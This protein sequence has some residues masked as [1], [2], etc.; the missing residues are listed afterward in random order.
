MR[1]ELEAAIRDKD[2]RSLVR[3]LFPS[4]EPL[5]PTQ[6][7]IVR[8]VG[9]GISRRLVMSCHTRFGKTYCIALG[10]ALRILLDERPLDFR[11][12]AFR[13]DQTDLLRDY[14]V[15]FI[16]ECPILFQNLDVTEGGGADRLKKEVSKRRLTFKDGKKLW[17]QTAAGDAFRLMGHGGDVVVLIESCLLNSDAYKKVLRMLGDDVEGGGW[18]IEEGN[19]WHSGNH[20]YQHWHSPRFRKIHANHEVGLREGRLN[21]AFLEEQRGELSP[22]EFQ[23]LYESRFPDA[24]ED[25]LIPWA[26]IQ[27]AE[28][29]PPFWSKDELAGVNASWSLDCAEGGSDDT[30]LTPWHDDGKRFQAGPQAKWHYA[31]TARTVDRV[32][33]LVPEGGLLY[34]DV[35]GVGKGIADQLKRRGRRIV[36]VRAGAKA[37]KPERWRNA[38]AEFWWR[39]REA[40]EQDRIRIPNLEALRVDL[41]RIRYTTDAGKIE[42][43]EEGNDSPDHG[44]SLAHRFLRGG[45]PGPPRAVARPN[46]LSVAGGM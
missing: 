41:S 36:E 37:S 7:E 28:T 35:V 43:Y 22:V 45:S 29:S 21:P 31:D 39:T 1:Q 13:Q 4:V 6:A 17:V 9:F 42:V 38:K 34:V 30:V 14:L 40:F 8:D 16:L 11:L 25:Q 33:E 24:S 10:L 15:G 2:V 32:A 23:V 20:F 27:R 3:W 12:L 5:S 46:P 18:F 44:D 19:P 26:W